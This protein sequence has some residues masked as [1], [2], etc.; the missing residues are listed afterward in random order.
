MTVILK[1]S[2]A[3]KRPVQFT[4]G[5]PFQTRCK[6]KLSPAQFE[7]LVESGHA[8]HPFQNGSR[9]LF[10]VRASE[11]NNRA[12]GKVIN[13]SLDVFDLSATVRAGIFDFEVYADNKEAF[14]QHSINRTTGFA[15]ET[16][17]LLS[18]VQ[19]LISKRPVQAFWLAAPYRSRA[20]SGFDH[21][22]HLLASS[23]LKLAK[24]LGAEI[25][26]T[27][28]PEIAKTDPKTSRSISQYFSREFGAEINDDTLGSL[29]LKL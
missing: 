19:S 10:T 2:S 22:S 18:N 27:L 21:L 4:P 11:K 16:A 23:G 25:L 9:L 28:F 14:A 1:L 13:I 17:A 6:A 8:E 20:G 12:F 15:D 5:T 3:I 26:R 7:A 29:I 24:G